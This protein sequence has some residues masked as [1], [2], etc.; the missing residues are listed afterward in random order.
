MGNQ[1]TTQQD[2][3]LTVDQSI[4][5]LESHTH[6]Q[7]LETPTGWTVY[8]NEETLCSWMLTP[9]HHPAYPSLVQRSIITDDDTNIKVE[10]EIL[11]EAEP[12]E[13]DRLRLTFEELNEEMALQFN[14]MTAD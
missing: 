10:M 11:C 9:S 7:K 5:Q 13:C 12:V 6:L 3:T 14:A 1:A 2:S 4:T 8:S